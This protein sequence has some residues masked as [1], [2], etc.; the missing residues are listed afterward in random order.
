MTHDLWIETLARL[1][2][3]HPA[4]RSTARLIDPRSTSTVYFRHRPDEPWHLERQDDET[5]LLPGAASDPDFVFRFSPGA[6]ERLAKVKGNSGDFAAELFTLVWSDDPDTRVNIRVVAGFA[7]LLR[8][9]YVRLM[10]T[11]G[12]R[13]RALAAEHGIMGMSSLQHL[14]VTIRRH[15]RPAWEDP[16][17]AEEPHQL[18]AEGDEPR[19]ALANEP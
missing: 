5:L 18:G 2:R 13:V 19:E 7:R 3:E 14:V 6:I 12:P 10:L 9:G 17:R 4:W 16:A 11:A 8:R 1:F 15:D